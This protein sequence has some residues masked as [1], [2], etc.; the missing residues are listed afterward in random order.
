MRYRLGPILATFALL[1]AACG[2]EG[3]AVRTSS[4]DAAEISPSDSAVASRDRS[5]VRVVNAVSSGSSVSVKL[6]DRTLFED[7]RPGAVSDYS[8]VETNLA[9]FS[10]SAPGLTDVTRLTQSDRMLVD[11]NR[12]TVF[13]IT[14]GIGQQQLRV[15]RD[16]I[17]ADSGMARLRVIHAAPSGPELDIKVVGATEKTFS[18][19]NFMSEAGPIDL[20]PD[21]TVRLELRAAGK[22]AVLLRLPNVNL[23]AGVATTIVV[24]GM[25]ALNSFTFTDTPMV[26]ATATP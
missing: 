21:A 23:R 7:L 10:V 4:A 18:G 20:K 13:V 5:M 2:K 1:L 26:R 12:Y 14:E 16:D 3:S 11:G 22:D 6:G 9:Q 17:V 19:V 24:T 15:V 25:K 8:E